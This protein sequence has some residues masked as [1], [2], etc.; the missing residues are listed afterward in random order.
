M[1]LVGTQYIIYKRYRS[2]DDSNIQTEV[3]KSVLNIRVYGQITF[4]WFGR[5]SSP[6]SCVRLKV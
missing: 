5:S 3:S 4:V 6:S 1:L 2:N